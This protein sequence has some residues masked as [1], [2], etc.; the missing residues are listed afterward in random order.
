MHINRFVFLHTRVARHVDIWILRTLCVNTN[1]RAA[2]VASS[3]A[4][5]SGKRQQLPVLPA[6]SEFSVVGRV[7]LGCGGREGECDVKC[8]A[9]GRED[10]TLGDMP[11][12][13]PMAKKTAAWRMS[14]RL[15][16][17]QNCLSVWLCALH[18]GRSNNNNLK[19]CLD[20]VSEPLSLPPLGS[21]QSLTC[22][23]S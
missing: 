1:H 18:R 16:V 11:A 19:A 5:K 10:E 14:D 9:S 13:F 8:L 20:I 21:T 2:T 4:I 22:W 3:A 23:P 6:L 17:H 12:F 15:N 7:E